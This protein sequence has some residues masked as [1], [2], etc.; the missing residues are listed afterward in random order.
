MAT[1][2]LRWLECIVDRLSHFLAQLQN[3]LNEKNS[4]SAKDSLQQQLQ[5]LIAALSSWHVQLKTEISSQQQLIDLMQQLEE[6]L[7]RK[8][9]RL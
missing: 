4:S 9:T 6:K 2:G 3:M 5:Q 8:E 7:R 1:S